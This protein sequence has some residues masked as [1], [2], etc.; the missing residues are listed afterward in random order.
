MN[1]TN[2]NIAYDEFLSLIPQRMEMREER[3]GQAMFNILAIARPSIAEQLRATALD[4]FYRD[5]PADIP[6][7][8]WT[9]VASEWDKS[10]SES[11]GQ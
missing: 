6:H 4:P 11:G 1:I 9:F 2:R 7:E 8:T 5:S 10:L 3:Y